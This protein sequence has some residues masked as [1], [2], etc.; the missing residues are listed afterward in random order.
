MQITERLV[1]AALGRIQ[2]DLMICNA[3]LVNVYTAE[4]E[5]VDISVLDGYIVRVEKIEK[6]GSY[7][8]KTVVDATGKYLIP[9]L[10]DAHSHV[11]MSFM[12]ATSFAEAVLPHGTTA[13]IFDTHDIGNVSEEC[14]LW[15]GKEFAATPLKGYITVPP[16]I[17]SSPGLEDAGIIMDL[18]KLQYCHNVDNFIAIGETMDFNRVVSAEP[19]MM[20]MLSWAKQLNLCIDGHCPELRGD[21]LQ[22]YVAAGPSTDHEFTSIEEALEKYRLGMK[23]VVRRGSLAEPYNAGELV[24]RIKD[25]SHLLLATDGCI[26]LET[27]VRKGTMIQALR[28]IVEEGVDPILAVQ[29]GTINVAKAYGLDRKIGAIAPGLCA[30]MILVNDLK[31]F[32]IDSVYVDGKKIPEAGKFKLPHFQ[33]PENVMN[34]IS[35]RQVKADDFKIKAPMENGNVQVHVLDVWE[36]KLISGNYVTN[37]EVKNGQILPDIKR[38][39]LKISVWHR[40]EKNGSHTTALVR[41]F[42]FKKG[43]IAGS[44]AQDSQNIVVI[45]TNDDDMAIAVNAVTKMQGSVVFV[46]DG[47]IQSA[48]ELRFGGIMNEKLHPEEILQK[49]E[50]FNEITQKFGGKFK[51]PA[52]PLSLMLTCACIPDLKI[53]NRSLVDALKGEG[54]SIFSE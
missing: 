37:V 3:Y 13:G 35:L 50:E 14:L 45:G 19:E 7:T 4:I 8:A 24:S 32:V 40:Y 43:A 15:F 47:K 42:G 44:I 27:I 49:F 36:D 6:R 2:A 54:I 26:T 52:F 34:T 30:D 23:I 41:G 18:D 39:L 1:Q 9:G 21:A 16:C 25:T 20:K 12:T 29:M 31:D 38:D 17:P 28:M 22:A 51:N 11:E 10:I 5:T 53:T 33:F 48:I 46:A